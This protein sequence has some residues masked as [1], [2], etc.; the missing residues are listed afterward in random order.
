[1]GVVVSSN[2]KAFHF[3]ELTNNQSTKPSFGVLS[4]QVFPLELHDKV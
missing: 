3:C 2:P 1:M 4:K